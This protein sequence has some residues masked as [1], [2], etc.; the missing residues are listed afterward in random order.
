M[1]SETVIGDLVQDLPDVY[2]I[3]NPLKYM[4]IL[5][6]NGDVTHLSRFFSNQKKNELSFKKSDIICMSDIDDKLT[7]YYQQY[8]Q[9]LEEIG[10]GMT[11][12]DLQGN[13][14]IINEMLSKNSNLYSSVSS[15]IH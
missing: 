5:T 9:Y 6:E 4:K 14:D 11:S 13:I 8:V 1:T 3:N 12:N 2:V 7:Y 10:D 15:S